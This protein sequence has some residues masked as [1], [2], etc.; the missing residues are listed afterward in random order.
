M[1]HNV[2]IEDDG[3][4]PQFQLVAEFTKL[5]VF[6]YVRHQTIVF[7]GPIALDEPP[8]LVRVL[9]DVVIN[10]GTYTR[11]VLWPPFVL[12]T[13]RP[14]QTISVPRHIYHSTPTI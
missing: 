8:K 5:S 1:D 9:L 13:Q 6:P 11:V 14:E 10:L 7:V 12:V 3:R 4:R 2:G